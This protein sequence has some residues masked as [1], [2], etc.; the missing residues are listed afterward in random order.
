[1]ANQQT[2]TLTGVNQHNQNG[3]AERN[4]RIICDRARAMLF[5]AIEKWPDAITVCLWP[6]ALRMAADIHNATPG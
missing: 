1:M 4:I 6:F 5:H 3:I 2:I